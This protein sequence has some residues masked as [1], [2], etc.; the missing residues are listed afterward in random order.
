LGLF[1]LSFETVVLMFSRG[2]RT[3][4][5]LVRTDCRPTMCDLEGLRV[6]ISNSWCCSGAGTAFSEPLFFCV[7]VF[8]LTLTY[9]TLPAL[10]LYTSSQQ[11]TNYR[12]GLLKKIL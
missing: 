10:N 2:S 12:G 8:F 1:R 5:R 3:P 11:N 6:L 9:L 7:C 4:W